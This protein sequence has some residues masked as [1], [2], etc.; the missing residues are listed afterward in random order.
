MFP[1]TWNLISS[2]FSIG[3]CNFILKVFL[4]CVVVLKF[5]IKIKSYGLG[6]IPIWIAWKNLVYFGISAS[7]TNPIFLICFTT[8]SLGSFHTGNRFY[9]STT[10]RY[11]SIVFSSDFF[12]NWGTIFCSFLVFMWIAFLM[13]LHFSLIQ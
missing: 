8:F 3:W 2:I 11:R 9:G 5:S 13:H 7:T 1:L 10:V 6:Y 12:S 4:V